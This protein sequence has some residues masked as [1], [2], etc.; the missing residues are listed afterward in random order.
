[1]NSDSVS[2][3]VYSFANP[4][5]FELP[6]YKGETRP[7]VS[8]DHPGLVT[9]GCNIHDSMLGYILVVDTP[10][11]AV[12]DANGRAVLT[13]VA[14]LRDNNPLRVWS[15]DIGSG[16]VLSAS[17]D[18]WTGI[19]ADSAQAD[20]LLRFTVATQSDAPAVSATNALSWDDY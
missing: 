9:L 1:P 10:H 19:A 8:F 15:P 5:N 18:G 2:H 14:E 7:T 11:F 4:Y 16:E 3:H 6:L 12:T 13:G 20:G 17:R